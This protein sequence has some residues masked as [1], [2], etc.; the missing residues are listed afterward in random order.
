MTDFR[1]RLLRGDTLYGTLLAIPSP[2]VAEIVAAAGFDWLFVDGEHGSFDA[3]SLVAVLRAAGDTP[4]LVR[5]PPGDEPAVASA[6][7]A[8]AAGVIAPQVHTAA[9]AARLAV[10]AHFP[11]AG[12]RGV[13]VTRASGY[14]GRLGEYLAGAGGRTAVVVQAES[15]EAVDNIEAIARVPG[16][17]AVFVGPNDLAASLGHP[18]QLD[19]PAVTAAI[20]RVLDACRAAG[21]RAGIFGMRPDAVRPWMERGATL[22]TVGADA[23]LLGQAARALRAEL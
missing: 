4:C 18:G 1:A 9:A 5:V 7:D 16:V 15:A 2:D 19:H 21:R 11:P 17:D 6:L 20:G 8:G 12:V 10:L 3:A 23:V 13:G 14:G 22:V